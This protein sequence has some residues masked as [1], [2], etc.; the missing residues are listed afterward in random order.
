MAAERV[1]GLDVYQSLS[2]PTKYIPLMVHKAPKL[3]KLQ[4][5]LYVGVRYTWPLEVAH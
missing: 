2:Q 3:T 4:A 5:A 1:C